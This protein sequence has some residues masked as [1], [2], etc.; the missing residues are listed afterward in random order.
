[1][2][3]ANKLKIHIN[4][5]LSILVVYLLWIVEHI[6]LQIDDFKVTNKDLKFF[7]SIAKSAIFIRVNTLLK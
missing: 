4:N 5:C 1:M 3:F 6:L 2:I 7:S